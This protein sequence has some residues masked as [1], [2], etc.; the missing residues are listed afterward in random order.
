MTALIPAP[1]TSAVL[2]GL[3]LALTPTTGPG[4]VLLG[5]LLALAIPAITARLHAADGQARRP[6]A[7]ARYAA[8]VMLDVLVSNAQVAWGV[9]RGRWRPP[10]SGFVVVPLDL[11][12]PVGLAMLAIVTTIIPGTV[13]TELALDRDRLLLHVWDFDD[14]AAFVARYKARYEQPLREIFER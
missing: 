3:W 7:I 8:I 12:D 2:F 5:V 11:R 13:W 14:E 1:R 10:K 9:L 4:Q 6:L